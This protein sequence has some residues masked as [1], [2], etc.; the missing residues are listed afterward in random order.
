MTQEE[1][2]AMSAPTALDVAISKV[3]PKWGASRLR[4]RREFAYEAARFTRLR[5]SAT[6]IQGPE[7]YTAFPDRIQLIRE[8][9]DLEQNF[10]LFQSIIDKVALYAFGSLKYQAHTGDEKIDKLYEDYL[11]QCFAGCD[12]SGRHNFRQMVV[13]ADKSETRDGDYALKWQRDR[14]QLKLVGVEGDRIGGVCGG[15]YTDDYFQGITVDV[16][17]GRPV[18][19]RIFRRTKANVYIDPVE[20]PAGDVLFLSDPRRID[21]YRGIT[22]FAPVINE[23]RDLKEVLAACLVGTKFENYH[24]AVGYTESGAPLSDPADIITS[25]ELGGNSLP[26]KEQALKPGLIQ[27]APKDSKV[28][29]V[30]SDRPS[31]NFQTY[32]DML[33][34][35]IGTARNLPYGFI[36]QLLGTGPAVRAELQ[37]AQR[38]IQGRQQNMSERVMNPAKNTWLMD[39]MA[40]GE[41]PYHENWFRGAWQFPPWVTIDAGRDSSS[42]VKELAAGVRS[43]ASVFAENGEDAEDQ[44]LVIEA[45]VNR[46]LARAKEIAKAH[47]VD[48]GV[49]LTLL[50]ARTPNG[51]LFTSGQ[52]AG[53][54]I[55]TA[56]TE[57]ADSMEE[58]KSEMGARLRLAKRAHGARA[59]PRLL[60]ALPARQ[61]RFSAETDPVRW[62]SAELEA[63]KKD[64]GA[65]PAGPGIVVNV[66]APPPPNVTIAEGAVRVSLPPAGQTY[67]VTR[68]GAGR[69]DKVIYQK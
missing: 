37:Q 1:A 66:S 49:V 67:S 53:G 33:V 61:R 8:M 16:A 68:D 19:Y 57:D 24:A 28:Q 51:F 55:S 50:D 43:K 38:V 58:E 36:Y 29:F 7:D 40:R 2:I 9:R 27:W 30:T 45:E 17:T 32:I 60:R 35:L 42:M 14:G 47:E 10:G 23:A 56:E 65:E 20:V 44:E 4:A 13:I 41:I 31:A 52:Q 39:G 21:Q 3:F 11:D 6:Q 62:L 12:L 54:S 25:T 34:R 22:P 5:K 59:L 18:S 46:T 64:L 48:L 15:P 69:I 63:R 26:I